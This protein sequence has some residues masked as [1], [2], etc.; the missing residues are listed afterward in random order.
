[1]VVLHVPPGD[2]VPYVRVAGDLLLL[3][4]PFGQLLRRG[5]EDA[6]QEVVVQPDL[7]HEG[8]DDVAVAPALDLHSPNVIRIAS[9][10]LKHESITW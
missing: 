2:G 4:A 3:E 10:V 6:L 1:M 8:L 5:G 7:G 9:A